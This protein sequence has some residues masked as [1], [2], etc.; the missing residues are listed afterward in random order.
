MN[1]MTS[2]SLNQS[3]LLK[4]V[5]GTSELRDSEKQERQIP[6]VLEDALPLLPVAHS[7]REALQSMGDFRTA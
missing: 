5:L 7:Y 3:T 4:A 2:Q 6:D 1:L